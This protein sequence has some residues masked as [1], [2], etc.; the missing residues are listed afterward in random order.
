MY[1]RTNSL[2]CL[3]QKYLKAEQ[4]ISFSFFFTGAATLCGSRPPLRFHNS[5]VLCGGVL[6]PMPNPQPVGP[7]TALCLAPT[8]SSAWHGWLYRELM[9]PPAQLSGSL[10]YSNLSVIRGY[11]SRR[12]NFLRMFTVV[13]HNEFSLLM[14]LTEQYFCNFPYYSHCVSC[15]MANRVIGNFFMFFALST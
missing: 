9:L 4:C 10:E 1:R 2:L 15:V 5:K 7:E 14:L 13:L 12:H 6:S 8:L 11:L 3:K